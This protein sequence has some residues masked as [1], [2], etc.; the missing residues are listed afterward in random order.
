MTVQQPNIIFILADQLRHDML[1]CYEHLSVI[2][3]NIDKL[4]PVEHDV[5][6][7]QYRYG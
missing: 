5:A 7:V 6:I 4:E 3:P 1:G 2:T